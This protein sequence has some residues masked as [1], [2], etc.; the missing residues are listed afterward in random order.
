MKK[1]LEKN[2]LL[3]VTNGEMVRI[4]HLKTGDAKETTNQSI[5]QKVLNDGEDVP[6]PSGKY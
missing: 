4:I 6:A 1:V 2:D 5:I 3:Y